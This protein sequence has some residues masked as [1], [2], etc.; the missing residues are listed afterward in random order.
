MWG[1]LDS[2]AGWRQPPEARHR[3]RP[4]RRPVGGCVPHAWR[5]L[6]VRR[7]GD[8]EHGDA[9]VSLRG[10]GSTTSPRSGSTTTRSRRTRRSPG[11]CSACTR[12][13]STRPPSHAAGRRRTTTSHFRLNDAAWDPSPGIERRRPDAARD[14]SLRHHPGRR[15]EWD[16]KGTTSSGIIRSFP[17]HLASFSL[18]FSEAGRYQYVCLIHD[19]MKAQ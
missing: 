1:R 13:P 7:C 19:E 4:R 10:P 12:S 18:T 16:G 14:W 9:P 8:R 15:R 17:P 2:R 5:R 3:D 6:A 11:R